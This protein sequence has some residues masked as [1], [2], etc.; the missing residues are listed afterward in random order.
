MAVSQAE[1]T[2]YARMA[3]AFSLV[4]PKDWRAPIECRVSIAK[5]EEV[6]VTIEE[7]KEAI[8]YFTA[9]SA[10]ARY[11]DGTFLMHETGE[12]PGYSVT[13]KGYRA[14]PAGP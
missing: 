9:T 1:E 6:G 4:S 13:A 3:V 7:V 8:M 10:T 5:L 12:G 14:G 2:R 11:S